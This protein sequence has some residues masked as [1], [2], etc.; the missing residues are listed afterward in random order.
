MARSGS[1]NS[2]CSRAFL[3]VLAWAL[4]GGEAT[5]RMLEFPTTQV[6]EADVAVS[7]DGERLVFTILGHLYSMPVQGGTAEQLTFGPCYDNDPAFA[8]DGRRIAFVSDRDGS[9]G[10]LFLLGLA[11]PRLTQVTHGSQAGQ[12][13][14]TPDGQAILYLRVLPWET[15]PSRPRSIFAGPALCELRKVALGGDG[16][17][18]ILRSPGLLRSV[19]FI[20]GGQPAW[21]VVEQEG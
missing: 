3:G 17:P 9:G 1:M 16:K 20:S 11:T 4:L 18:E 8:P 12:P 7:P 21:T 14:W 6:T 5:T 13:T 19:F 15:D 2:H 10:N